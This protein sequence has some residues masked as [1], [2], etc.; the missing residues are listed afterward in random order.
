MSK[1]FAHRSLKRPEL[2]PLPRARWWRGR[3]KV[4]VVVDFV[5]SSERVGG[6]SHG[7]LRRMM[8]RTSRCYDDP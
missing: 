8:L 3:P 5:D 1:R 7:M 2:S 4:E 6:K